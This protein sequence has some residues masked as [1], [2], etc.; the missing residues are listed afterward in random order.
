MHAS[1]RLR[2]VHKKLNTGAG[3]R[4]HGAETTTDAQGKYVFLVPGPGGTVTFKVASVTAHESASWVMGELE[5]NFDLTIDVL[6]TLYRSS[7]R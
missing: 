4:G 1:L 3:F 7:Q 5:E 2:Q 6:P